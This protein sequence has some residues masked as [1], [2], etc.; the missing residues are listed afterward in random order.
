MAIHAVIFDVDGVIYNS[1]DENKN[2]LWT[3]TL[4]DDT[5]L[6]STHIIQI[7][8]EK[9]RDVLT[10]KIDAYTHIRQCFQSMHFKSITLSPEEF[11]DYWLI[12]DSYLNNEV[13]DIVK[14]I[15]VPVYLGTN[16]DVLRMNSIVN[17]IGRYF[18]EHFASSK[19][20]FM[21]PEAQFFFH[22]Q[23]A[24]KLKPDE[25]LIIDD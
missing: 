10:G 12:K 11:I 17:A 13:I 6:T 25:L 21:K 22:I 18:K 14:N 9:W 2:F 16:Q 8:G 20:G 23:D 1:L 15:K 19:I 3:T 5:K 4:Y 24:L 7:F